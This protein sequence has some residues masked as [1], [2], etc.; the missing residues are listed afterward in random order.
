MIWAACIQQL[1]QPVSK[2]RNFPATLDE[3]LIIGHSAAAMSD[4]SVSEAQPQL[5][6][7]IYIGSGVGG[8]VG[9]VVLFVIVIACCR[10]WGK[11]KR[12]Y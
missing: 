10:R 5:D 11:K 1:P 8:G 2:F 12:R 9:V 3:D 4:D 6:Q 7:F